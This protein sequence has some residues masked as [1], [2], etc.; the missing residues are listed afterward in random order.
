MRENSKEKRDIREAYALKTIQEPVKL[1]VKLLRK[2]INSLSDLT[3]VVNDEIGDNLV[4]AVHVLEVFEWL[5]KG[6]HTI[7]IVIK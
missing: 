4:G 6:D 3:R 7:K 1:D 2:Q 5:P